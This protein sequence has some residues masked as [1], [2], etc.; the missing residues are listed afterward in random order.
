MVKKA[1]KKIVK[2]PVIAEKAKLL[3]KNNYAGF[4]LRFAAGL[5]DGII[6]MIIAIPLSL[7]GGGMIMLIVGWLYSALLESSARQ[8]T[9]GKI[10]MNIKVTDMNNSR[11]SFGKATARHFSKIISALILMIGFI[12]IAFTEKKQGLHDII[13]GSLVVRK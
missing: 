11:I 4:W 10:A 5:I 1:D 8:A 2:K 3:Q 6:L 12:M 13:A 9:I 7:M